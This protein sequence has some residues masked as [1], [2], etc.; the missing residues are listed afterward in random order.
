MTATRI[1]LRKAART[2][3]RSS[4]GDNSARS[5]GPHLSLIAPAEQELDALSAR[6][7]IPDRHPGSRRRPLILPQS[8]LPTMPVADKS[9]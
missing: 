1:A 9:P 5:L 6:P 4:P 3:R 2:A 8:T 7:A